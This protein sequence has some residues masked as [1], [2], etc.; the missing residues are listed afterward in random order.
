MFFCFISFTKHNQ[1]LYEYFLEPVL[2]PPPL[3]PVYLDPWL[4]TTE[5]FDIIAILNLW[6]GL[7]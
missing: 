5:L 7:F 6:F 1:N 2:V 4:E 3:P